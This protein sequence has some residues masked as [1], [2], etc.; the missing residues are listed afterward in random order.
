MKDTETEGNIVGVLG[1]VGEES[2]V[3]GEE[4]GI[5]FLIAWLETYALR[6]RLFCVLFEC[7]CVCMCVFVRVYVYLCVCVHV[8][9]YVGR[10]E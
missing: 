1:V 9:V 10:K 4:S 8:C 5:F 2:G 6:V 3:V 7:V